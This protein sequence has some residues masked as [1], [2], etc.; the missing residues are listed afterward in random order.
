VLSFRPVDN[1]DEAT[2]LAVRTWLFERFASPA[3][4]DLY[5]GAYGKMYQGIWHRA[6][7][8][9]G[10]DKNHPHD[11][12]TTMKMS[13]E[14]AVQSIDLE[15]FNIFDIDCYSSP[16][17]VARRI[18]QRKRGGRFGLCLT[19]GESRGLANGSSNE[20]IR[21]TIGAS[22]L[23]DLRLLHRYM[24]VVY[25]L[26]IRSLLEMP[27]VSFVAGVKA[28]VDKSSIQNMTYFSLILDK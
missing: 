21:T 26:M 8:Y 6:D 1:S 23:S 10:V 12:G 11:F 2:K 15:R 27:G 9:F 17:A 20:I 4:L 28:M 7:D 13:A 25:G 16:W 18:I 24:D 14:Q 19:S 22:G 5:C 3:V